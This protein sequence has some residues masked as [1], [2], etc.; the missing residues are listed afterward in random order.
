MK[1]NDIQL[2]PEITGTTG[3]FRCEVIG[4]YIVPVACCYRV[5]KPQLF[6]CFRS[7]RCRIVAKMKQLQVYQNFLDINTKNM[8]KNKLQRRK[9]SI[10]V[11]QKPILM[12]RR[13][14]Q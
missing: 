14:S 1:E 3:Y 7:K 4:Q 9:G 11:E 5:L 2:P 6:D 8:R 10:L 12:R 13:S